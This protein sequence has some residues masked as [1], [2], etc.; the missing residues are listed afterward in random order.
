ML[1]TV[2]GALIGRERWVHVPHPA[3]TQVTLPAP[4]L[5]PRVRT[6]LHLDSL[7]PGHRVQFRTDFGMRVSGFYQGRDQEH[8]R[9]E[10]D[11]VILLPIADIRQIAI[12]A[13]ATG[14]YA[15]RGLLIGAI[16]GGLGPA[17]AASSSDECTPREVGFH[18][19]A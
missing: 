12:P 8:V 18:P 13:S 10:R 4:E 19:A 5:R 14:A 1:G 9:V 15:K 11:S 16:A 7:Q 2:T 3:A 17:L 6:L